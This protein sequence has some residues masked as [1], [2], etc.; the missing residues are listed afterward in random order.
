[1]HS[2]GP[3]DLTTAGTAVSTQ[4]VLYLMFGMIIELWNDVDYVCNAN[5][6]LFVSFIVLVLECYRQL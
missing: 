3:V 4:E 1:M 5:F 2:F 6:L